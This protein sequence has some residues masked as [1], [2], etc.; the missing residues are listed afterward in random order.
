MAQEQRKVR[1]LVVE[2]DLELQDL[3]RGLL[4][5][6]GFEYIRAL[7]VGDAV[8]V[9][10]TRPLPNLMVLDLMLPDVS[11]FELLR[12]M[13]AKPIFDDLPIIILSALADPKEIKQGLDLGADRY[14]TKPYIAHNLLKTLNDVLRTGRRR[15]E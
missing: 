13:R 9:L 7:T 1:V 8:A 12:Q 4:E 10:R 2:D 6:A 3:I 14:L 5:R 15:V 11:G